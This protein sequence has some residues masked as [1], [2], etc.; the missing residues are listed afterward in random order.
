MQ[1]KCLENHQS[2]ATVEQELND[3]TDKGADM[4]HQT[5]GEWGN[6]N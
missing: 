1:L 4:Q 5:V 3:I 6:K 2:I